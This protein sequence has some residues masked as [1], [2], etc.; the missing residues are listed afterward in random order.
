MQPL[1]HLPKIGQSL[2]L[3]VSDSKATGRSNKQATI[4]KLNRNFHATAGP[5]SNQ[6][7]MGN[8]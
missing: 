8:C 5:N 2:N 1:G 6:M 3:R 4:L 7:E